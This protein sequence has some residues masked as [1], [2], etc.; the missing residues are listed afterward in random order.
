MQETQGRDSK[1][2]ST[3]L[4]KIISTTLNLVPIKE[5]RSG[6]RPGKGSGGATARI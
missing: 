6:I 2:P 5:S 1:S 3:E 4:D